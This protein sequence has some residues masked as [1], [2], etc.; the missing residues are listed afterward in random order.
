LWHQIGIIMTVGEIAGKNLYEYRTRLN[1]TQ[2]QVA[3][4]L[5]TDRT[6][7]SKFESNTRELSMVH[8]NK[9]AIF[10]GI[11]LE[12]FL[13]ENTADKG[14]NLAF[15]FR[16]DGIVDDDIPSIMTFKKVVKNYLKMKEILN[17]QE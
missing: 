17:E 10:F 11:E 4:C 16:T 8:L 6:M 12:D 15:A 2:D 9:L 14:A 3:K 7:I 1:Y 13:E 5:N